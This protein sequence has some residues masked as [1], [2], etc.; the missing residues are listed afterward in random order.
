MFWDQ[1]FEE[2]RQRSLWQNLRHWLSLL[3]QLI[4]VGLLGFAL[5][6]PLWRAQSDAGQQLILIVD[7][8]ASMQCVDPDTG[9]SR[10]QEAIEEA[11]QVAAGLR[12]GDQIALMTAG[13]SVRVIVGMTDF[14]P[15]IEDGLATIQPTDG[16]TRIEEAIEAARRLANDSE[17][18]RVVVLSDACVD[19]S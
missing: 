7:N 6:D 17:R 16:P 1:V 4:F 2:K 10:L 3:L 8:S 15:A 13:N 9:V 5:A 12:Q 14:G 19:E 11:S 18:R